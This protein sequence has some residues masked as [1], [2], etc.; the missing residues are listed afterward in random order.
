MAA[1]SVFDCSTSVLIASPSKQPFYK[2]E[3]GSFFHRVAITDEA[4]PGSGI[5]S[6]FFG[7]LAF[8]L[9]NASAEVKIGNSKTP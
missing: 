6:S 2:S 3:P 8:A 7:R 1:R 9:G 4:T 5:I